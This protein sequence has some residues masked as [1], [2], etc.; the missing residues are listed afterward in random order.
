MKRLTLLITL[1]LVAFAGIASV[2]SAVEV[3]KHPEFIKIDGTLYKMLPETDPPAFYVYN[4][5]F[6]GIVEAEVVEIIVKAPAFVKAATE[7]KQ[8]PEVP[9]VEAAI[10]ITEDEFDLEKLSPEDA[11]LLKIELDG[12]NVTMTIQLVEDQKNYY[13]KGKLGWSNGKPKKSG[14]FA[15][16][17]PEEGNYYVAPN[18]AAK[19]ETLVELS[20]TRKLHKK[21]K[22]EYK[23]KSGRVYRLAWFRI[24]GGMF[25]ESGNRDP[26]FPI[27]RLSRDNRKHNPDTEVLLDLETGDPYYVPD[28]WQIRK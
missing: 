21:A 27:P 4:G 12:K 8:Y 16:N 19:D 1:M 15:L 13:V 20:G 11:E 26:L 7:G 28:D 24:F 18:K 9:E 23:T 5:R 6:Y 14:K 25:D 3:S 2:G 17:I 10:E 22:F